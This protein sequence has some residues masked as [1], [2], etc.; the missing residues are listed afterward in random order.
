MS[1]EAR[2]LAVVGLGYLGRAVAEL[3][4]AT[5]W[6][7][8]GITASPPAGDAA[9]EEASFDLTDADAVRAFFAG[10]PAYDWTVC[11]V[12]TKGGDPEAYRRLYLGGCQHLAEA[13]QRVAF[14]GSTSV[15]GQKSGE[16]V[17]ETSPTEPAASTGTVLL[18]A[19][20]AALATGGLVVRMAGLY[21][22]GRSVL[23]RKF[24]E[25][26]ATLEAGG[27]RWI[28]QAHRD[29][30]AAALVHLMS[31][32]APGIYNLADNSPLTQREVYTFLAEHFARPLPPEGPATSGKRRGSSNKRVSN[33]RLR[34]TGW[35][36]RY[37]D[38]RSAVKA[39]VAG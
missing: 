34:E 32:D 21:G 33:R 35:E 4:H 36:P 38:F 2:R 26:S 25:G 13:G 7:V 20:Q 30:A 24:L 16:W 12:S 22:P 5:G 11:S 28:N 18:E 8:T 29:D 15:Y 19:E 9:F 17:S 27:G 1:E 14:V 23:M 6:Q 3:A 39:E 37:P 10:R 31:R